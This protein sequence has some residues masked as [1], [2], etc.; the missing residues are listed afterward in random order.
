MAGLAPAMRVSGTARC[1][2]GLKNACL[3]F[4]QCGCGKGRALPA[5]RSIIERRQ[6]TVSAEA[7]ILPPYPPVYGGFHSWL[8]FA[9]A[10]PVLAAGTE[11]RR[12][13]ALSPAELA[14]F[15]V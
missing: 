9:S 3:I 15:L 10:L 2:R 13:I 7:T 8:G 14:R 1:M 4:R 12:R 5:H 11:R 6:I